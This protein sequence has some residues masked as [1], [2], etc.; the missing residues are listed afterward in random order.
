LASRQILKSSKLPAIQTDC[1]TKDDCFAL[2]GIN[3]LNWPCDEN[4]LGDGLNRHKTAHQTEKE[5]DGDVLVQFF[6]R[7]PHDFYLS[8][9]GDYRNGFPVK[10][11]FWPLGQVMYQRYVT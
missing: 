1:L 4:V 2:G 3:L 8:K 9:S 10:P 11:H 7:L 5:A 6:S